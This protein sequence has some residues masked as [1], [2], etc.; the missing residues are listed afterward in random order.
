MAR[1]EGVSK[2][3]A[4]PGD[5]PHAS[6][7]LSGSGDGRIRRPSKVGVSHGASR[8][9]SFSTAAE[10]DSA[11]CHAPLPVYTREIARASIEHRVRS[12]ITPLQM[13]VK[14]RHW[15]SARPPVVLDEREH[16]AGYEHRAH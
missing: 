16:E 4:S 12:N 3:C 9:I 11:P 8:E 14:C 13:A 7:M 10:V 1:P 15:H 2:I 5:R 6:R